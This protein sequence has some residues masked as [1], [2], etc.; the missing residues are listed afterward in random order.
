MTM[1]RITNRERADRT[2]SQF[3]L[4][5]KELG[6]MT[7]LSKMPLVLIQKRLRSIES[8]RAKIA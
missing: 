2:V 8:S 4:Y 5:K 3:Q 7:L 1:K 6:T